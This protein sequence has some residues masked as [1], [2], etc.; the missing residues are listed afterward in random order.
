M[1]AWRS[2][3]HRLEEAIP[4]GVEVTVESRPWARARPRATHGITRASRTVSRALRWAFRLRS[5]ALTARRAGSRTAQCGGQVLEARWLRQIAVAFASQYAVRRRSHEARAHDRDAARRA[6]L[7][8]PIRA[9]RSRWRQRP[10]PSRPAA[11]KIT[12]G[13]AARFYGRTAP[14]RRA[15]PRSSGRR[16]GGAPARTA[17]ELDQVLGPRR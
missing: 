6:C 2:L 4:E 8:R 9:C 3:R 7:P 16:R 1:G 17:R 10:R 13:R 5:S 15:S 14:L 12:S 11:S